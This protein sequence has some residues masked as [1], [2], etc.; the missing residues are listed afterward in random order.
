MFAK[1]REIENRFNELEQQIAP[2]SIWH[3]HPH[4]VRTFW[5]FNYDYKEDETEILVRD[6]EGTIV[7]RLVS[8]NGKEDTINDKRIE[9]YK[10][11]D[12]MEGN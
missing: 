5:W 2:N 3:K 1:V 10:N 6:N 8:G 7:D 12:Y 4:C 9:A 11:W